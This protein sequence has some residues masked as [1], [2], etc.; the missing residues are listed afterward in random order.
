MSCANIA[1]HSLVV[2]PAPT[3][4]LWRW[5]V[6]IVAIYDAF[7]EALEMR[8]AAHKRRRLNDE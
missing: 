6:F 1:E 2:L 5:P 8:R 3:H 7:G 4:V